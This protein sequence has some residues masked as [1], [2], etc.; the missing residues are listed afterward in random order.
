MAIENFISVQ[1]T[2]GPKL[3]RALEEHVR[4]YEVDIMNLQRASKLVPAK[5]TGELHE[6]QFE[7]GGSLK[8]KTLILATGARW[9]EMGVPGEQEYKAKGVCFCPHC[10]GPLFKGKRVAVIGTG[11]SAIQF[12]PEI[13]PLVA[14][15]DLYQRTPP[16][17]LPKPDRAI[18]ETER[19]RF[20][21]FPLVQKLWRGGLYSLLEGRVLGFTF[22][23][24]VMKLVQRLAIRHI[25]KQIKDPE[26]RRKVKPDYTIGCKRILMSHNYYPAL[27]AAN[28]TVITEGI[29][30]VTANG[31]VDGNGREREV[32]AIIFGTGFTAN[33]PIPRGVVFGR[34]G[35]DLLD[36]WTKGP[37]AYKGTT[38][39]GFP[40]LFFLMGPNTGLGHNSMVY[41]IESQIAYVLDALKLMKRRELLSLEV[42]A[43]VQERYNEY[44]QRKLD[45]SVWSVGGCK[46]WYLHPVSGRNCTL[47][48]GF[49][50]RFRALTRQFDASAYHLTTTPLAALSNEARQQAEGVPA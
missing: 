49:T 6:V 36:S 4:H 34:D 16:W 9:R 27:A 35:R 45:R 32:D 8:A 10:D 46:S 1:E 2:E 28:S 30:A 14:A 17:I 23:P 22:A 40:N 24:Q 21:R 3:A 41:M 12:V 26:L 38:T 37:E 20:R 43:P 29:R 18:S 7:S 19:R 15:L 44:L 47:W 13:Q 48:P 33:D 31:I 11:A 5:N 42:K 50:W 39:A 25:H